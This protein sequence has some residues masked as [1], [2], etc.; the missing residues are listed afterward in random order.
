MAVPPEGPSKVAYEGSARNW[1]HRPP[2]ERQ[3]EDDLLFRHALLDAYKIAIDAERRRGVEDET[4]RFRVVEIL[5]EGSNPP[6]DYKVTVV[7][8][9]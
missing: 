3:G 7:R 1:R 8:H 6:S 5:V 9:P 4:L 2:D